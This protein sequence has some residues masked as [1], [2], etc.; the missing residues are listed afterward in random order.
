MKASWRGPALVVVAAISSTTRSVSGRRAWAMAQ[1]VA[2]GMRRRRWGRIVNVSSGAG[3]L[4]T[5]D[6][7]TPGYSASKAALNALDYYKLLKR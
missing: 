7:G 3:S 1:A 6:R 4:A 2:P 5:M